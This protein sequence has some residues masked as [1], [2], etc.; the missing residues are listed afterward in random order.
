MSSRNPQRGDLSKNGAIL[1]QFDSF[2]C[3]PKL[4]REIR[5][6][7]WSEVARQPRNVDI[8]IK[9]A[10]IESRSEDS[11]IRSCKLDET[12]IY[13]H[14]LPSYRIVSRS[15]PP[16]VLQ[17][18]QESLYECRKFFS[19]EFGVLKYSPSTT[20]QHTT[21]VSPAKVYVQ[22]KVD[23]LCLINSS[24]SEL[25]LRVATSIII[26][27]ATI[28]QAA[29]IALN[30][31]PTHDLWG[32][33]YHLRNLAKFAYH[34]GAEDVII[35]WQPRVHKNG[36]SIDVNGRINWVFTDFT[37]NYLQTLV[38]N[39]DIFTDICTQKFNR[40]LQVMS[41]TKEEL[42]LPVRERMKKSLEKFLSTRLRMCNE[43]KD[44]VRS[45]TLRKK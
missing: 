1:E 32:R 7:I 17:T 31:Y 28:M 12:G 9:D 6:Q 30:L 19:L 11:K 23:R 43:Y 5:L 22:W 21:V 10:D 27:R 37:A 2:T 41:L 13:H 33:A 4:P 3:F 25:N 34:T 16:T 44:T 29:S 45:S 26:A 39:H 24:C 38:R 36:A 14:P 40:F 42:A 18:C 20:N 8:Y 15:P 35:V